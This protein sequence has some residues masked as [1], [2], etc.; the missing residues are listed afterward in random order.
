MGLVAWP[1]G[2]IPTV[3]FG[4]EGYIVP[5]EDGAVLGST[6]EKVGFDARTTEAGLAQVRRATS[7]IL[8]ALAQQPF[9][10]TWAGLRPMTQDALPILGAD[11]DVAGLVYS[12]GFGRN[13]ILL[14]PLSGEIVR[15]LV[16]H[17]ETKWDVTPYSIARFDRT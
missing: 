2:A 13:G 8:P 12:T 16:L 4:P 10:R 5:R 3:L 7:A 6:M 9:Q 14:G 11:P 1:S 17:G 15:D